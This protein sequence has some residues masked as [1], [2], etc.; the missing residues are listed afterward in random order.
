MGNLP[1]GSVLFRTYE[2]SDAVDGG[3]VLCGEYCGD[4]G[5]YCGAHRA[6]L[7]LSCDGGV[8]IWTCARRQSGEPDPGP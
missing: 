8:N 4:L 6:D 5:R 7:V 1:E 3:M 2:L